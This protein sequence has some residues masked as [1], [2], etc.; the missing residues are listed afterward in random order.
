MEHDLDF[1]YNFEEIA[2]IFLLLPHHTN[3]FPVET[4]ALRGL[5]GRNYKDLLN[6]IFT[7]NAT[8]SHKVPIII[9]GSMKESKYF[10]SHKFSNNF[11][12]K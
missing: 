6:M 3:S 11:K 8:I 10:R 5:N 1:V 4:Y 9:M 7:C 2:L 12:Y